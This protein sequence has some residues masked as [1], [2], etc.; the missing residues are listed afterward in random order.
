MVS[1]SILLDMVPGC[2]EEGFNLNE[3]GEGGGRGGEIGGGEKGGGEKG[4]EGD[5]GGGGEA[6]VS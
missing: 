6:E 3:S 5:E 4:G 1:K 2:G